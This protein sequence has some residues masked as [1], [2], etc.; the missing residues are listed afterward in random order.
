MLGEHGPELKNRT[1][2]RLHPD[3]GNVRASGNVRYYDTPSHLPSM[4]FSGAD[5]FDATLSL[6]FPVSSSSQP[7]VLLI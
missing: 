3:F 1:F 7:L 5:S 4:L 2:Q 6:P